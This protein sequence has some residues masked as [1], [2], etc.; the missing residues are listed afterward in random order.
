MKIMIPILKILTNPI[1]N[2]RNLQKRNRRKNHLPKKHQQLK[3]N[4]YQWLVLTSH[5][6]SNIQHFKHILYFIK[7]KMTTSNKINESQPKVLLKTPIS[8][9]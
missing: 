2:L 9:Y 7:I 3:I 1:R 6:L 5:F 4:N 8:Y